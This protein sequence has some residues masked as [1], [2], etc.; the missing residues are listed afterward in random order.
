MS[1]RIA[2]VVTGAAKGIGLGIAEA[3][4]ARGAHV[5]AVDVDEAGLQAVARDGLEPLVGDIS[6]WSTHERA[7]DAA[8]RAGALRWWVNNAGIDWVGGAHEVDAEH[9]QRG[10]AVLLEGPLFGS[11]VAVRRMLPARSGS[12]VNI[13][14]IQ[15]IAGF[16]RYLVYDA[17]KA[18]VLMASKQIAV[19]YGRF[20][21]RCNAVLPGTI[22]TPMTYDTLPPDVPRDEALRQEGL[23]APMERIGQPSEIAETVAFLLSDAASFVNGAA[24]VVD[25]GAS[26]RCYAYP[27]LELS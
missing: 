14:S 1:D 4:V 22:E 3:L 12:I 16:P 27:P 18:G 11:A 21:I 13:S 8:E 23:L 2:A 20:G 6:E 25:G 7:A 24:I 5:I 10:I 9:V 26:A 19:D 17:A 15:G